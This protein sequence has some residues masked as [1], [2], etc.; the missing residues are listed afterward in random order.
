MRKC[1]LATFIASNKVA[2]VGEHF[3]RDSLDPPGAQLAL[4]RSVVQVS[5]KVVLVLISGRTV[6]FGAGPGDGYNTLFED[7]DAILSTWH[8]GEEGGNAIWDIISG[9]VRLRYM[10]C[11]C[12][13]Q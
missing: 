1:T 12:F 4:L 8:P 2:T 13:I 10:G 9:A 7:I 3:D 11:V 5:P 6:T